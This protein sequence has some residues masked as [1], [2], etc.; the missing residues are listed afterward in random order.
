MMG[1]A[2]CCY[3][4][5]EKYTSTI[6][7]MYQNSYFLRVAIKSGALPRPCCSLLACFTVVTQCLY[8]ELLSHVG[9]GWSEK[10]VQ[11][12]RDVQRWS[13]WAQWGRRLVGCSALVLSFNNRGG[14]GHLSVRVRWRSWKRRWEDE[15][16]TLQDSNIPQS[17]K[18]SGNGNTRELMPV[19]LST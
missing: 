9:A 5:S 12:F 10:V 1:S 4:C 14:E 6:K 3:F 13:C 18:L 16:V 17:R 15:R 11:V 2:M 8:T 19:S 7:K